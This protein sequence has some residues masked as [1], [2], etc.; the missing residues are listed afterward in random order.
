M[1][2]KNIKLGGCLIGWA[3]KKKDGSFYRHDF[4]TPIHNT[5]TK[6]GVNNLFEFNGPGSSVSGSAENQYGT[7]WLVTWNGSSNARYGIIN[8]AALG[9][10]TGATT[11]DDT[12]LKHR[13]SDYTTTKQPGSGWCG[14]GYNINNGYVW[15]RVSHIHAISQDFTVKEI[16]WYNRIYPNGEYTLSARVQLDE[17]VNVE[18]GDTFYS[19]YQITFSLCS[20][21][22]KVILPH[23]GTAWHVVNGRAYDDAKRLIPMISTG[24][25]GLSPETRNGYGAHAPIYSSCCQF[26]YWGSNYPSDILSPNGTIYSPNSSIFT[27]T[28]KTLQ[29]YVQDSF[30]RDMD[31]LIAAPGTP[32]YVLYL[33]RDVYR[34][35]DFDENNTFVPNPWDGMKALKVTIRQRISTDLLQPTA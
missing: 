14:Y 1:L 7:N 24:G 34:L 6:S 13:V 27:V 2:S 5:I 28:T 21:A 8:S 3:I 31:V 23:F 25:Y 18:T 11:V 35:G 12:D 20:V 32:V 19:I 9:D 30:Y 33:M 26:N 16:G 10:G 22:E 29:P 15:S 4:N 17:P